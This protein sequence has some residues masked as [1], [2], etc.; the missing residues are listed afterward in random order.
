M[1]Y[2]AEKEEGV[3]MRNVK[4][5]GWLDDVGWIYGDL[6]HFPEENKIRIRCQEK[7]S[8]YYGFDMLIEKETVGQY[9][10]ETDKN[11]KEIYE[12][13]IL[14]IKK[15]KYV[16]AWDKIGWKLVDENKK[17]FVPKEIHLFAEVIGNIYN[18]E[19][20]R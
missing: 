13:D 11:N 6:M 5:R 16:V 17:K 14:R 20:R 8:L 12:G 18:K 19:I 10:D 1:I 15:K 3:L 4:F 7:D 9:I 2:K